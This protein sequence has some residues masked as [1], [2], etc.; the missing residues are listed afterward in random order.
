[1][2]EP[3]SLLVLAAEAAT[4]EIKDLHKA[5]EV[6]VTQKEKANRQEEYRVLQ[7]VRDLQARLL[8]PLRKKHRAEDAA[9]EEKYKSA[10]KERRARIAQFISNRPEVAVCSNPECLAVLGAENIKKCG[11]PCGSM[12][13]TQCRSQA[14]L[15]HTDD[16]EYRYLFCE[17]CANLLFYDRYDWA[18]QYFRTQFKRDR[19]GSRYDSVLC[20]KCNSGQD[21]AGV[22]QVCNY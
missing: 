22:W 6:E 1:M 13:C 21:F 3:K 16:C 20:K 18:E 19:D 12:F 15:Y 8:A 4:Q 11:G 9:L 7:P 2:F 17:E 10:I 5:K 14:R